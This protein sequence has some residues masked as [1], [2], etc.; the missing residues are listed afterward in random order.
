[1]R[2]DSG[3]PISFARAGKLCAVLVRMGEG[4]FSEY[5]S[6]NL[7]LLSMSSTGTFLANLTPNFNQRLNPW[8]L[9]PEIT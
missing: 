9:F 2:N 4:T 5:H 1:M 6:G 7:K 8:L 3:H